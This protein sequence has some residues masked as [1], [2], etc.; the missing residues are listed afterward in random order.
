MTISPFMRRLNKRDSGHHGR[1]AEESL[2]KRVGGTLQPGSGALDGAKGDVKVGDFLMENKSTQ[3]ASLSLKQ[4]WALKIYQEAL[5]QNKNPA[6]SIQFVRGNGQSEKRDRWV[7]I[8]EAMF[9]EL[10]GK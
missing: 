8:T 2:A 10:I 7:M 4:D 9:L 5:E 1:K 3:G 6:L